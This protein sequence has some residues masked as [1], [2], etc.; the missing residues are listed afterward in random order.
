M[1]VKIWVRTGMLVGMLFTMVLAG[2]RNPTDFLSES[3]DDDLPEPG[4]VSGTATNY[5]AYYGPLTAQAVRDLAR[6]D[7]AIVH[8]DLNQG[9]SSDELRAAVRRIQTTGPRTT[10]IAYISVG[11]DV[12]V[13]PYFDV[14]DG[15]YVPDWQALE[16][17]ER[18]YNPHNPNDGAFSGP[19]V[20]PRPEAP[21]PDG[22]RLPSDYTP[23]VTSGAGGWASYYLDDGDRNNAPNAGGDG[24]GRPD[25]NPNF[26]SFFVNIGDPAW[27][28]SL[29]RQTRADD[30]HYGISELVG[31]GG[32]GFDGLFLDTIDTMGPNSYAA[33]S[34]RENE[35]LTQDGSSTGVPS[36]YE[37]TAPGLGKFLDRLTSDYPEAIIVQNRGLFFFDPR[38]AHYTHNAGAQIDYLMFE[39][40]R[41]D[42]DEGAPYNDRFY[43]ENR[44][45]VR[46]LLM[47]AATQEERFHVLSL[48]YVEG[49]GAGDIET[50]IAEATDSGF[51]HYIT[52]AGLEMIRTDTLDTRDP[53]VSPDTDAPVWSTTG[54]VDGTYTA[55]IEPRVGIQSAQIIGSG[56]AQ[57]T[58]DLALDRDP[59]EYVLYRL[60]TTGTPTDQVPVGAEFVDQAAAVAVT[61][62]INRDYAQQY[63]TAGGF[64]VYSAQNDPPPAFTGRVDGFD[65]G[66][67][68]HLLLRAQDPSGNETGNTELTE[69]PF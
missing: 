4:P 67:R 7:L 1:K 20:D 13:T 66:R 64:P 63:I 21:L 33:F 69:L 48:G 56:S 62:E 23:G 14:V 60:D 68:Y 54:Y 34:S 5:A 65:P 27:Y 11:E 40:Y 29:R 31:S 46:Q 30:G 9:L 25:F 12:R 59:V 42:S 49:A 19:V 51:M 55:P 28:Q 2:C 38:L 43:R 58:F 10:V 8:P 44:D 50:D 26:G 52:D 15:Q 17:E 53:D 41:L 18:F 61:P 57:L 3:A 36:E 6:F 16:A 32:L 45:R 35:Q 37:W 39:S 47:T 22:A 24:D